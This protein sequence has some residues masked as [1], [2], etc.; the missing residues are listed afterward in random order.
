MRITSSS[1]VEGRRIVYEIGKIKASSAWRA[2]NRVPLQT[3]WREAV[4]DELVQKAEDVDADAI[5]GV[6][7]ELDRVVPAE[8]TGVSLRRVLATGIAVKLAVAA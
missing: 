4:L 3:N 5:I 1:A 8:Q 7:Y 2:A 6:N